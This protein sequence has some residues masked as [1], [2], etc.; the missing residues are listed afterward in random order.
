MVYSV[1]TI[2]YTTVYH[3]FPCCQDLYSE[4]F[5]IIISNVIKSFCISLP[6]SLIIALTLKLLKLLKVEFPSQRDFKALNTNYSSTFQK[7]VTIYTF[8]RTVYDGNVCF[9]HSVMSDSLQPHGLQPARLLCPWNS[10]GKKTG[11]GCHSLLQ[12]Y[13]GTSLLIQYVMSH[14]KFA[15]LWLFVFP[16]PRIFRLFFLP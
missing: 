13:D 15:F 6:T 4:Y 14:L 11:V 3:L 5:A 9:R 8:S 2:F 12:V 10:P 7:I 1:D 16:L